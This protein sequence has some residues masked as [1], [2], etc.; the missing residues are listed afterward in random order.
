MKPVN[1]PSNTRMLG[2]P[3]GWDQS[4]LP[5]EPLGITDTELEGVPCVMSFWKPDHVDLA[6]ITAG[7]LIGLSIV[8]RTMPPACVVTIYPEGH[9]STPHDFSSQGNASEPSPTAGMNLGERIAHVGGRTNAAGYIEFGSVMAVDAL[10]KQVLRDPPCAPLTTSRPALPPMTPALR[11]LLGTP[12]HTMIPLVR[13][14]QMAG[15]DIP[16]RYED[17]QAGMLYWMLGFY[18][19]HG[20]DW[21]KAAGEELERLQSAIEAR[22]KEQPS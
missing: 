3:V 12:V 15:L 2:A 1:H 5:V 16:G 8:G 18:F 4:G 22:S 9:A 14:L 17:E 21:R 10:I 11:D 20:D 19:E 7:G 6:N 13:C